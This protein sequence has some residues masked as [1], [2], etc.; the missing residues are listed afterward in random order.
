[1]FFITV[2]L[3][4]GVIAYTKIHFILDI[5]HKYLKTLQNYFFYVFL[6]LFTGLP[7]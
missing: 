5:Q 3:V 7:L 4:G 2:Y 6:S 1:V